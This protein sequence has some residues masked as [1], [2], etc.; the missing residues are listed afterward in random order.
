[1]QVS[2]RPKRVVYNP[3]PN[4]SLNLNL[5]L[6]LNL[7]LTLIL[8]VTLTLILTLTLVSVKNLFNM[9]TCRDHV[10]YTQKLPAVEK[11]V[12]RQDNHKTRRENYKTR[13]D[14][15]CPESPPPPPHT[16][17]PPPPPPTYQYISVRKTL[18]EGK[19]SSGGVGRE[20]TFIVHKRWRRDDE[21]L[22]FV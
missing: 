9:Y 22:W 11:L 21:Y 5:N 6:N 13:R 19:G 4:L 8:T 2:Q 16:P 7:T 17:P 14:N 3:N 12:T 18:R 1:M 20:R 10:L 15:H